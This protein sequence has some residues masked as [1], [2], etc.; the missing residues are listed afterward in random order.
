MIMQR[1]L[2][3]IA[4]SY[5]LLSTEPSNNRTFPDTCR[6]KIVKFAKVFS[7]KSF[8]LYGIQS[9]FFSSLLG[10][11]SDLSQSLKKVHMSIASLVTVDKPFY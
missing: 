2:S 1:K 11:P 9:V 3:W 5:R 6:N 8:S 10:T 4:R 7:L